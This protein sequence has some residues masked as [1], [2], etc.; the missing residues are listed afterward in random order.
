VLVVALGL[1]ISAQRVEGQR[2]VALTWEWGESLAGLRESSQV[3]QG[4]ARMGESLFPP[5]LGERTEI[6][7]IEKFDPARLPWFSRI[8]RQE[9]RE[10]RVNRQSLQ[11]ETH[12]EIKEFLVQPVGYVW[13]VAVKMVETLEIALWGTILA[14]AVSIPLAIGGARNYTPSAAVYAASRGLVSFL[15]AIPEMISALFLVLAYGFGPIAGVLALGLHAAG[16]LG[17]F[18]AE[19]VE[20][21]DRGPQEAL[22]AIGAGKLK[23]LWFGVLPQVFPQYIAYTLYV[24]DRNVRMAIVIGIVGAGGIGQ[25]LKGRYDMF[26]YGHVTTILLALFVTVFLLDQASARIRARLI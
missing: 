15:R 10:V 11:T 19:D 3:G 16:F 26:N 2:F 13:R 4:L 14:V 18:Y 6:S 9:S 21:A 1:G 22:Q 5:Q 12:V 20:N 8:E 17:K 7:R 23:V 24:L 25:E